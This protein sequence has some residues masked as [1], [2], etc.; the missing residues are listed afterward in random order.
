MQNYLQ[1]GKCSAILI[2]DGIS[3]KDPMEKMMRVRE[4]VRLS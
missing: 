2:L 3:W 1:L 4:S